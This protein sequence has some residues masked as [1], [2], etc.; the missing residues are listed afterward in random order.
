[1]YKQG[2]S[3]KTRNSIQWKSIRIIFDFKAGKKSDANFTF[4]KPCLFPN[5]MHGDLFWAASLHI[6]TN[7]HP[8][9]IEHFESNIRFDI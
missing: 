9:L 7:I 2:L 3:N 6:F 1:M 8:N 5:R 4:D